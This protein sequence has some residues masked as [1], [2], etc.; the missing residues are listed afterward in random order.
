MYQEYYGLTTDP[1]RL[2]PDHSFCLRHST[3][4]KARAYMQ[5]AADRAE[6]FVMI[7][8]RPGTGKTTLIEDVLAELDGRRV[9]AAK[10]VSSQLDAEDLLHMVAFHFGLNPQGRGK[11]ALL[12]ELQGTFAGLLADNRRP[13]LIIDE[14]Q[15]LT[16]EALEELR[17]LTNL[18]VGPQPMLQIF[19][20]GQ[21]E[22]RDMVRDPRMEQLHQRLIASC[23]LEPLDFQ[24]TVRYVMHRLRVAGWSG[25]PLLRA[26]VFVPLFRFS[27]GV[28]RRIN[29]FMGRL[30]LHGWL[31][32]RSEL[33]G[34]DAGTI[35]TELQQEHLAPAE[36]DG[37]DLLDRPLDPGAIDPAL[38]LP[39]PAVPA[40]PVATH[41]SPAPADQPSPG[42]P[43]QPAPK[44]PQAPHPAAATPAQPTTNIAEPASRL[45]RPAIASQML[46]TRVDLVLTRRPRRRG[47]IR[48][49]LLGLLLAGLLAALWLAW[50]HGLLEPG[51]LQ[52]LLSDYLST[53]R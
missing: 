51:K 5:F 36:E 52:S 28:P 6:G 20:V 42:A 29:L 38:L 18:R 33:T 34:A 40:P 16:R 13:L 9:T 25:N 4:A 14:A 23:H 32:T 19:L 2:S 22:L 27:R 11:S 15:G 1:F 35:L 3:F 17:L 26:E 46:D 21:D 24:Q 39:E 31:E 49:V 8:G 53:L 45:A 7:T 50:R 10:L 48:P 47:W 12:L 30:L 41:T 44:Q 37:D 43:A